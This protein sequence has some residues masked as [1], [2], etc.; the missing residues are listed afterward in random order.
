VTPYASIQR[1]ILYRKEQCEDLK[2]QKVYF[3]WLN[4]GRASFEWFTDMLTE[5]EEAGM[6]GF[7]ELNNYMT[8][9][10]IDA[11]S[12]LVKIGMDLLGKQEG[13][14]LTTGLKTITNFGR[15]DWAGIFSEI[16]GKKKMQGVDVYF[17]GPYP[18]AQIVKHE[19][20]R[21]GF[22]FRKENF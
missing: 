9:A 14:D 18:L 19:A 10:R 13:H 7:I 4:R 8:D 12:G 22:R 3:F 15:P 21:V 5:I 2:L 11:T 17:C 16:S 6:G 1:S 20:R